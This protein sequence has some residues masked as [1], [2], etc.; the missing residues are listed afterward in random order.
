MRGESLIGRAIA[1][2][3]SVGHFTPIGKSAHELNA[4]RKVGGLRRGAIGPIAPSSKAAY[5]T[6]RRRG[7][8]RVGAGGAVIGMGIAAKTTASGYQQYQGPP[9]IQGL[10][11]Q[12]P[13]GYG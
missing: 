13:Y 3:G 4:L 1:G 8:M 5:K 2:I 11:T 10:P 9:S 6:L 7:V 12:S